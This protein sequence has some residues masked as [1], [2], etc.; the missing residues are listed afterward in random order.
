M[1]LKPDP[2]KKD[3]C[4]P[5]GMVLSQDAD[6]PPKCGPDSPPNCKDPCKGVNYPK[7]QVCVNGKCLP[8]SDSGPV[9]DY[10][11][12]KTPDRGADAVKGS[13][14]DMGVPDDEETGCS[15]ELPGG[16]VGGGLVWLVLLLVLGWCR[17][18]R[19]A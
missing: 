13:S 14:S 3:G 15:C 19:P 5:S 12:A 2:K 7:G 17:R 8:Q 9:R 1:L 16:Q 11:P 6:C 4:C 18:R 10:W